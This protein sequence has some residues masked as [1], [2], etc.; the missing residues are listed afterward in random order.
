MFQL[1]LCQIIKCISLV[2][3]KRRRSSDC[4]P[5]I[6]KFINPCIM[7]CC[8]IVCSDGKTSLQK[9]FPFHITVAGNTRIRCSSVQVFFC[10]VINYIFLEFLFK[11]HHI[12]RNTNRRCNTSCIVYRTEPTT[13]AVFFLNFIFLILPDLHCHTDHIIALFFQKPGCHGGVNS[14]GHS[15]NN[16]AFAH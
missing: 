9:C 4:I 1:F 15:N 2:F 12:I 13:A 5:S 3:R 8:D 6:R 14:P 16:F 10:K 11:I 7:S